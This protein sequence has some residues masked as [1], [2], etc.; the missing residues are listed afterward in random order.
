MMNL[1]SIAVLCIVACLLILSIVYSRRKGINE[2][3][4]NCAECVVHCTDKK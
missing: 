2:C 1:A 3:N 4:G